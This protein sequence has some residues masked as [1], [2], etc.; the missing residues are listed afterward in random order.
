MQVLDDE[1]ERLLAREAVEHREQRLEDARLVAA[2]RAR[3]RGSPSPGR[4]VPS[5]ARRLGRQ[6]GEHRVAVARERPQRA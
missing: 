4:S 1:Q 6:R 3:S 2:A 5:S